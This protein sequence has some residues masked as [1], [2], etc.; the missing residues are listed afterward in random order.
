MSSLSSLKLKYEYKICGV[1]LSKMDELNR[2]PFFSVVV[3]L[4]NK[5]SKVHDTIS[6]VLR[7]KFESFEIVIVNDG[8]TDR[9][10]EVVEK[11]KDPRV[12]VIS[13][14]NGGV[15]SARNKGIVESKGEYIAFLDADDL[16]LENHLSNIY[17]LIKK[18]PSVGLYASSY[19]IRKA[20][21]KDVKISSY[22]LPA[23]SNFVVIPSYIK[24]VAYG[25]YLVCSSAVCIPKKIFVDN[26]IWFPAG[27]KYGEDK[28]VWARVAIEFCAAYCKLEGAIYDQSE[29]DTAIGSLR[30]EVEPH[31]SFYMI[32][33]LRAL[34]RDEKE[35]KYFDDYISRIF[36][37]FP[38]RNIV[39]RKK[40]YGLKQAFS[41][42]LNAKHKLKIII[43][44]LTPRKVYFMLKKMRDV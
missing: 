38:L 36:H 33:E 6:T 35:Y 16:W 41:L 23:G 3:P 44:F 8:S 4:Y 27:E 32:K 11:I 10:A 29:D 39:Y 40:L 24:S 7:Q 17:Q 19:S 14:I 30:K 31:Q 21:K 22:G 28:Y 2:E 5:E 15:S 1:F 34:I 13:T 20:G 9:S 25:D 18:F 43:V 26:E 42:N 12:R 37:A